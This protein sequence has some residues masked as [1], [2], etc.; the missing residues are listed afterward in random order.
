LRFITKK[1]RD[2]LTEA[3]ALIVFLCIQNLRFTSESKEKLLH[4]T[5]F[6]KNFKE[7]LLKIF[8]KSLTK[9]EQKVA[10]RRCLSETNRF[11]EKFMKKSFCVE[12]Y[13]VFIFLLL[14]VCS[15]FHAAG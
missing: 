10:S 6:D 11:D 3:E 13:S 2:L 4:K 1:P 8:I 12:I 14:L 7:L 5:F 15:P 9:G